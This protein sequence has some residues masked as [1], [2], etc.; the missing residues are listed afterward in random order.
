MG[1]GRPLAYGPGVIRPPWG[2]AISTAVRLPAYARLAMGLARDPR[3]PA[4]S[5]VVLAGGLAYVVSPIDLVPGIIPVLGQLDDLGALI[6]AIKVALRVL[7]PEL[8]AAHLAQ[9]GLTTAQIDRDL[10]IVRQFITWAASRLLG[11]SARVA[12]LLAGP[13]LMAVRRLLG[14]RQ[15]RQLP[16]P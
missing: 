8:A 11:R 15:R 4:R 12:G 13:G 10:D 6:L 1:G 3:V 2:T 16:A 14:P 5:K 9:A 7:P